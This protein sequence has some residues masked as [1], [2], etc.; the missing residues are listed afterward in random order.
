VKKKAKKSLYFQTTHNL[1]YT[2]TPQTP[3]PQ[4]RIQD[5]EPQEVTRT[6]KSKAKF[7]QFS[8]LSFTI[9]L[10]FP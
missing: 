3:P 10:L 9:A 1:Q 4:T 5:Y 7:Y 8:I 6:K 2:E